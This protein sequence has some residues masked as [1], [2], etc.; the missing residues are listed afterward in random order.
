MSQMKDNPRRSVVMSLFVHSRGFGIAIMEDALT[1]LN[2]YNVVLHSYPIKNKNVLTKV[3]EKIDFYL[4][5]IIILED[6]N[7]FGSRKGKRTKRL[8]GLIEEYA[9]PKE[10]KI[11]KYSRNDIRFVFNAFNARSKYEIAK[12]IT[13]NV[14]NLPIDLPDKRKSH[15]PEHYSM[16]I[17]DAIALGI[18]H[19]YK[20]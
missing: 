8:I 13:E 2:A 18:T 9:K 4:P 1:L 7:G 3:K 19:F 16:N 10:L 12:V 15:E 5:E 17:F 6:A 20:N 11:S 14:K